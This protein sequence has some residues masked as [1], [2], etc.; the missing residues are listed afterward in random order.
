VFTIAAGELIVR[1]AGATHLY[2]ALQIV[3]LN[4]INC[5]A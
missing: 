1:P 2:R 4:Y 5:L 3:L